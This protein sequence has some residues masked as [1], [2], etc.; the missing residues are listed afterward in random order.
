[1]KRFEKQVIAYASACHVLDHIFELTYGVVLI[2]I[3]QEFGIGLF[4]LGVLANI[5][6]FTFGLAALPAGFLADRVGERR[7]LVFFCLGSG[8]SSIIV[9]LAPNVYVLGAAL[10]LLGLTIGIYHPTGSAFITRSVERRGMAFGYHGM[11]GN[12]GV[13]IAPFLA[14]IIAASMGW[15]APY[16]I[17]AIPALLLAALIYAFSRTELPV[18]AQNTVQANPEK[19]NSRSIVLPLILI[20]LASIT[21]GLVYK[22]LITFLP[23]YFSRR[24]HFTLFDL[25]TIALAGSFTTIALIFGVAGQLTGGYLS[26]RKRREVLAVI[27]AIAA[28]P[29]LLLIGNSQGMALMLGAIAFAFFHFMGQPIFNTLIADYS[30][31]SW[32][33]RTYGMYFFGSFGLGSFSATFLGYIAENNDIRWVFITMAGLSVVT[34]VCIVILFLKTLAAPGRKKD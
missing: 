28:T 20:F 5:L 22:G 16:F 12:L 11:A 4:V 2:G 32:R 25:D 24:L 17:F 1:M 33:G 13:A 26:E 27:V 9:G 19:A 7:L 21:N 8:I 18:I 29:L 23:V 34:V 30:P 14:G 15:R 31:S 6:G 10:A 3:A